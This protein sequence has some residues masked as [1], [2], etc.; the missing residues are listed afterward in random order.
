ME[1]PAVP[2]FVRASLACLFGGLLSTPASAQRPPAG[3]PLVL[4]LAGVTGSPS[5]PQV[6]VA[7]F[8]VGSARLPPAPSAV[9]RQSPAQSAIA[10]PDRPATWVAFPAAD[11]PA[12][13][14]ALV[15]GQGLPPAAVESATEIVERAV[16]ESASSG[17]TR[18]ALLARVASD[19]RA[20]VQ[21]SSTTGSGTVRLLETQELRLSPGDIASARIGLVVAKQLDFGI[22]GSSYRVRFELSGVG[23]FRRDAPSP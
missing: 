7:W 10:A 3:E 1:A 8:L 14:V 15:S 16:R 5:A 21:A 4:S 6:S 13:I 23:R 9:A 12:V 20:H 19:L 11:P 18:P 17:L 22:E 2:A